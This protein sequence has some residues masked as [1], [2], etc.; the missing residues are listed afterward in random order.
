MKNIT[1]DDDDDDDDDDAHL[2]IA[3]IK[4]DELAV[5]LSA[6]SLSPIYCRNALNYWL[7]LNGLGRTRL[8]LR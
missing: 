4:V 5:Y 6:W 1:D 8:R 7:A 2:I 3:R